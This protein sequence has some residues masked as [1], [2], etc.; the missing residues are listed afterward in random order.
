[1]CYCNCS[2]TDRLCP[3]LEGNLELDC[4]CQEDT[5]LE[6]FFTDHVVYMCVTLF[7]GSKFHS[8]VWHILIRKLVLISQKRTQLTMVMKITWYKLK[9]IEY[10][11]Q[12]HWYVYSSVLIDSSYTY[13]PNTCQGIMKHFQ[14][15]S[16]TVLYYNVVYHGI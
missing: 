7:W 10:K 5:N 3:P 8:Q 14:I 4:A 6:N 11:M 13:L 16:C 1:M 2:C 9:S 12:N 15:L